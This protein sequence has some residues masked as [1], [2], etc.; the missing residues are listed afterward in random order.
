MNEVGNILL[1][2][3]KKHTTDEPLFKRLL[4]LAQELENA[5]VE[6]YATQYRNQTGLTP[7]KDAWYLKTQERVKIKERRKFWALD[8]GLSGAFLVDKKT[9]EIYNI[10]S[11]GTPDH[12][13]KKKANLGNVFDSG[14]TGVFMYQRRYNYLR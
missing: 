2:L 1:E 11:Y 9:G 5:R 4:L 8:I 12:N 7:D 3:T 14:V 13:K 10:K 6:D